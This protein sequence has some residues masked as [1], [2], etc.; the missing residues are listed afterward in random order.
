MHETPV[1]MNDFAAQWEDTNERVLSAVREVGESGWYIL[2]S[3]VGELEQALADKLG[4]RHVIG[5]ASGLDA[6]EI[7]LR[8]LGLS[9]G[10]K[11]LTTPTSAFA[12]TL[13][14]V[15][16]G[17]VPVFVDVDESGLLDLEWAEEA[18]SA[19]RDI[20]YV[21]PVHLFGHALD[22]ARLEELAKRHELGV[23]E[24]CCQAIG[25]ASGGR[26]VGSVGQ[27]SALS[28]YPTKNLGTLGDG[29]ALMTD[30]P[31][32]AELARRLRDYGQSARFVH[33]RIGLNSRLDEL[34]ACILAR[35]FLPKLDAWTARRRTIAAR[36]RRELA[37]HPGVR[38]L[39]VPPHSESVWH[40]FPVTV[41]PGARA[42]FRAHLDARKV[43]SN[44]HYP[45]AI[46][47][48]KA[49]AEVPFEVASSLTRAEA[50]AASEV[51]LPIHPYMSE[52]DVSRV[53]EAVL[54]FSP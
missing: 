29:G 15:R 36:Y 52:A 18:L 50:L 25:A 51:S 24:D 43:Q 35:A 49:L 14:I 17:G 19:D 31:H 5:C 46:P 2:G 30:A 39:P 34:H 22:L 40:L 47:S 1:L 10:Q 41:A 27:V 38:V 48:Q 4:R 42:A 8:A 26:P 7:G 6:I 32:T 53:V 9:P 23:L 28:F 37:D 20:R 13:A 12:T 45:H 3:R 16:A 54:S 44:V 33:E 11:V 21:V